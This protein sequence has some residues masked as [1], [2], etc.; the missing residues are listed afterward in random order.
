MSDPTSTDSNPSDAA[1]AAAASL[2]RQMAAMTRALLQ[3][4][5]RH[6]LGLLTMSVIVVVVLTAYGQVRLNRWNR[7]FYN[8]LSHHEFHGFLV[9]L[10]VFGVIAGSLLILNVAQQWLTQML[11]L[12]LREGLMDD[13]LQIW[14][15]P[16]RAFHLAHAGPIGV[17]PDQRM[18]EDAL[19]LTQLSGTLSI[20]LLQA[21]VLLAAFVNVLWGISRGFALRLGHTT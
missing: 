10:G 20:G 21:T 8:A 15:T 7:P 13:L 4:P 17:N 16:R 14:L 19:H 1:D 2:P 6:V 5:T 9:Q 3:S 18:H 12:K 11:T